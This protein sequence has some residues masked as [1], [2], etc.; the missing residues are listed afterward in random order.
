M[1]WY[2]T[3]LPPSF[4]PNA[5]LVRVNAFTKAMHVS[6]FM[7][8]NYNYRAYFNSPREALAVVWYLDKNVNDPLS[9]P[10][11]LSLPPSPS[12]GKRGSTVSFAVTMKLLRVPEFGKRLSKLDLVRILFEQPLMTY[13]V[14][15]GIYW[16][17]FLLLLKKVPFIP[18]PN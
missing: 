8:M 9:I 10:K 13:R 18:H 16:Q 17:A 14:M 11:D 4:D 12:D 2:L 7:T 3:T 15:I 6:P 5:D 1:I